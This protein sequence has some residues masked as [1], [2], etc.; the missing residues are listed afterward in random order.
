MAVALI[1]GTKLSSYVSIRGWKAFIKYNGQPM[2]CRICGIRGHFAI[3]HPLNKK[4]QDQ[5]TGKATKKPPDSQKPSETPMEVQVIKSQFSQEEIMDTPSSRTPDTP[6][7]RTISELELSPDTPVIPACLGVT[8]LD[9]EVL[10]MPSDF[11]ESPGLK[12]DLFGS[13]SENAETS[14]S[15]QVA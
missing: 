11:T 9:P 7:A 10:S 2:T 4:R 13:S 14:Q 12:A 3:Y 15:P 6:A 5:K 8:E 1:Q